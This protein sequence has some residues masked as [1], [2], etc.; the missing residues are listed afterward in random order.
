[1][2][3]RLV[4]DTHTAATEECCSQG[5]APRFAMSTMVPNGKSLWMAPDNAQVQNAAGRFLDELID[6]NT[7]KSKHAFQAVADSVATEVEDDV[8]ASIGRQEDYGVLV[9]ETPMGVN[10]R[11]LR[12]LRIQQPTLG[13]HP[14]ARK[15][16]K[17]QQQAASNPIRVPTLPRRTEEG[18]KFRE[19]AIMDGVVAMVPNVPAGV[20]GL[21]T[22]RRGDPEDI[23]QGG[24]T[25]DAMDD[26]EWDQG[27]AHP[28]PR[29][30]AF[31]SQMAAA[32]LPRP[33]KQ[34]PSEAELRAA[35]E[36][37]EKQAR[38]TLC[39]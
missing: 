39:T 17:K 12:K 21:L 34:V 31:A 13:L 14:S 5:A 10:F 6:Q 32:G 1:M 20:S 30:S 18:V 29:Q 35:R 4:G 11:P 23:L 37:K 19:E 7:L 36:Q 25:D 8:K 3:R 24:N 28:P 15:A 9:G 27:D 22:Q 2:V 16:A 38:S 33:R 26:D